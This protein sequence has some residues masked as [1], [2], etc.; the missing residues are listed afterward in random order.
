MNKL[1]KYLAPM[2]VA[3]LIAGV[4][5]ALTEGSPMRYTDKHEI[6]AELYFENTLVKAADSASLTNIT[7]LNPTLTAGAFTDVTIDGLTI[8][9][10]YDTKVFATNDFAGADLQTTATV[11]QTYNE[12]GIGNSNTV[13]IDPPFTKDREY[14]IWNM[15]ATNIHF[16]TST[17]FHIGA[18]ITLGQYDA[19]RF[20]AIDT[21]KL[22]GVWVR[23]N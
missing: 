12:W 13:I 22:S 1:H 9:G 18:E 2:L 6:M 16:A 3:I 21:N 14:E 7:L 8:N 11:S 17:V 23:N 5:Y 4:A 20:R 19:V 10:G 15:F